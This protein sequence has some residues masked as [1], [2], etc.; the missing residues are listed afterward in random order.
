VG[1]AAAVDDQLRGGPTRGWD[2]AT[3][4]RAER[5]ARQ[6]DVYVLALLAHRDKATVDPLDTDQWRFFAVATEWL[7][8][9]VG[10]GRSIA[11]AVLLREVGEPVAYRDLPGAVEAAL[12]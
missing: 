6:A 3:W 2:E 7:D 9:R 4:L 11:L 12:M 8:R 10:D 1:A 5:P